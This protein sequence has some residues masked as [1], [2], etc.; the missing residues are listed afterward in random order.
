M[1]IIRTNPRLPANWKQS[2]TENYSSS[3]LKVIGLVLIGS[4]A[5]VVSFYSINKF[6]FKSSEKKDDSI[7]SV[8]SSKASETTDENKNNVDV[9]IPL[10]VSTEIETKNKKEQPEQTILQ[11]LIFHLD[12]QTEEL[13]KEREDELE[14]AKEVGPRRLTISKEDAL[15]LEKEDR[16]IW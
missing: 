5:I 10:S 1:T 15:K 6:L 13:N 4:L 12:K 14:N 9:Y 3:M 2:K 7:V 11:N 16:L 8:A